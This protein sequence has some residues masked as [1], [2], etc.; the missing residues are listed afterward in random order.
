MF[1]L[2]CC[3]F[4]NDIVVVVGDPEILHF[5]VVLVSSAGNSRLSIDRTKIRPR[6]GRPIGNVCI[7]VY[8]DAIP[9]GF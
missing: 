5:F 8:Q 2:F 9:M 7:A 1:F 3:K 4:S 6:C